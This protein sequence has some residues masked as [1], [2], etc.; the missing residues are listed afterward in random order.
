MF[1]S[2]YSEVLEINASNLHLLFIKKYQY[3]FLSF[4]L[5]VLVMIPSDSVFAAVYT[6]FNPA[7]AEFMVSR[8]TEEYGD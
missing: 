2:L 7:K 1:L 4:A 3:L 8:R 5:F 6:E